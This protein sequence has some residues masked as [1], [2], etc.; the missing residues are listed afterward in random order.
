MQLDSQARARL[1]A[2]ISGAAQSLNELNTA[3]HSAD[4]A[5]LQGKVAAMMAG[6]II[7][8]RQVTAQLFGVELPHDLIQISEALAR[9]PEQ[10]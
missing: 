4:L 7:L 6:E 1:L 5:N 2:S 9:I 8:L 3:L 10:A